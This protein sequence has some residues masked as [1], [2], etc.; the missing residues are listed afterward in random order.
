MNS[1]AASGPFRF[2]KI[3]SRSNGTGLSSPRARSSSALAQGKVTDAQTLMPQLRAEVVNSP[4]LTESDRLVALAA[5]AISYDKLQQALTPVDNSEPRN[6][7]G[8]LARP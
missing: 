5:Y 6:R 7:S 8:G 2:R 4:E 3:E 1:C